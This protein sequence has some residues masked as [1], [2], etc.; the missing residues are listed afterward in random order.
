[1]T[2][3]QA[4]IQQN[5][6]LG[7][8]L[9]EC[10]LLKSFWVLKRSVD[11]DGADFLIQHRDDVIGLPR[12]RPL[13]LG[14]V[15]A[16]FFELGTQ[17]RI[18]RSY[19]EDQDG[20]RPDFFA[21]LHTTDDLGETTTY[22][23]PSEEIVRAWS[24]TKCH[25]Y[26]YFSITK[27]REFSKH[28]NRSQIEI[29]EIIASGL[30]RTKEHQTRFMLRSFFDL[31]VDTRNLSPEPHRVRYMFRIVE[32]CKVVVYQNMTTDS[33]PRTLE[34]RRDL[35]PYS[36]DFSWGYSGTGPKFLAASILGHYFGG[37][38]SPTIEQQ[39]RLV[40]TISRIP[41]YQPFDISSEDID[42]LLEYPNTP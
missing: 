41:E 4:R 17:V 22:F 35:F 8:S 11:I 6:A 33:S 14:L 15:Q 10:I 25:S 13:A 28:R 27:D 31:Y 30:G 19:V 29:A 26:F 3:T 24:I 36:G 23:F 20:P 1:M 9:T 16:K 7:A 34:P 42:A 5:A 38:R 18:A 21:F 32:G 40:A 39:R 12:R 2:D 37:T